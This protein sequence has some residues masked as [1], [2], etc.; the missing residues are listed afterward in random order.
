RMFA[1][2]V[3]SIRNAYDIQPGGA[4]LACFPLFGLFNSAMGVTTV[5]P[6]MD[7]SR[8]ASADPQRLLAAAEDW[9]VTQAFASPAVWDRL[10]AHCQSTGDSIATLRS[11]FSCGAPV[12]ARVLERTLHCVHPEARMHTPYGATESLPVSTIE[13]REVL[14]ETAAATI[15]GRGV[16]VG[17]RFASVEWRVIEISDVALPSLEDA[18]EVPRGTV[19]ELIVKAP[20]VSPRYVSTG[21]DLQG[22]ASHR[23]GDDATANRLSK[24]HDGSA[25]WHRIGDVGYLDEQDRFWYCGRKSHRVR[26]VRGDRFTTP[27]EGPVNATPGVRRSALVGLGEPGRQICAMVIELESGANPAELVAALRDAASRHPILSEVEQ[28]FV[29]P[30]LPVDVRHNSKINRE[31]LTRWANAQLASRQEPA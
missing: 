24:I 11:V 15:D 13:A 6:Q 21:P 25:V 28:W 10:S 18:Q 14:D 23:A 4:D 8:P 19:G 20:Q 27:F 3:E 16:C 29:H 26:T 2:Q 22:A 12:P 9:R 1:A 30:G 5:F 7:F 31:E 17:R